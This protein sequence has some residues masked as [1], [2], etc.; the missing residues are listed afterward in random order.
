MN[1]IIIR[2]IYEDNLEGKISDERF[3]ILLADYETEQ[4]NTERKAGGL[5]SR[6]GASTRGKSECRQVSELGKAVHGNTRIDSRNC[7]DIH[8]QDSSSRMCKTAKRWKTK[9][10]GT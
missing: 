7:T 3:A 8:W 4:K 5:K 9:I 6:V 1:I 10:T 2:K